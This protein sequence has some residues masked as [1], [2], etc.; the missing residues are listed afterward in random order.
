MGATEP[1]CGDE[2]PHAY[3]TY[4]KLTEIGRTPEK[5]LTHKIALA[6]STRAI[7]DFP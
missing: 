6:F 1:G 3:I 7:F 4:T 5:K 2:S